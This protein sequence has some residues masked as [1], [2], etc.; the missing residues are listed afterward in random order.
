M[1]CEHCVSRRAFLATAVGATAL[2]TLSGCGDGLVANPRVLEALPNGPAV[3]K[4][5]DFPGLATPGFLVRIPNTAVAVKRVDATTFDALSM[6]C[7]HQGCQ[8]NIV[9]GQRFDCPCHGSR[10]D[11]DGAV[12]NGP[13]TGD[14]IGPLAKLT[15]TYNAAT[16]ELTIS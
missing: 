7:T 8:T 14:T 3:I 16:D 15:A 9:N 6:I 12:I 1:P 4:V 11:V 13:T 2:A 10:F 5:A